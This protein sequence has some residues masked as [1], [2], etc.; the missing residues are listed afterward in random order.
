MI[1]N[2]YKEGYTQNRELSWLR[3]ND[4]VL[5]EANQKEVP[6][7]EREKFISIYSSNLK[8][9]F[10]IRV[11]SL[12]QA[13][14]IKI[15]KIDNKSGMNAAGQ[16]KMIYKV[17]GKS[18]KKRDRIYEELQKKLNKVG[19]ID[20]QI[21][22]CHKEERKYLKEYFRSKIKPLLFP[23]IVDSYHPFPNLRNGMV[24]IAAMVSYSNH[25]AF[26]FTPIPSALPALI[27]LPKSKD[28]L[29]RYVHTEDLI[30]FYL[31][32]I[33][34][35]FTVVEALKIQVL[36]NEDVN[37]DD[38]L[39]DDIIDY[40]KKM[41]K[42]LNLRQHQ[43]PVALFVSKPMSNE[44]KKYLFEHLYLEPKQTYLTSYP[45]DSSFGFELPELFGEAGD[46]LYEP[47][48]P[49][50]SVN[51]NYRQKLFPQ[52]LKHDVLLSYPYENMEPLL[53]LVKEAADDPSVI[54]IKITI[55]RLAKQARLV[56]YL[57]RA[58]E[59][60]KEVITLIE[61]KARFDEQVNIDYS[62]RLEDAGCTVLYGFSEYKVHSKILLITRNSNHK[63]QQVAQIATGNFNEKTAKQYTDLAY[64]T[65]KPGIVK[66]AEAFFRNMMVGKLDGS[67]RNLLVAPVSLKSNLIKLIDREANKKQNGKIVIKINSLTDEELIYHLSLASKAGVEI[68]MIVRGICCLLPGIKGKTENISIRSIVGRY[69]EHSRIYEFGKGKSEVMYISSADFMT[70]NT[71]RRVEIACPILDLSIRQRIN[72]YLDL[73]LKDTIKARTID[74]QGH[75]ERVKE[76]VKID[77]QDLLM[78]TVKGSK[79]QLPIGESR[80]SKVIGVF[81]TVYQGKEKKK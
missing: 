65:G 74:A 55:Y 70:R 35:D 28:S 18:I 26:V 64:F 36:R 50:L 47:Y 45:L 42:V 33:F 5:Q 54:S 9:F 48:V 41:R 39:F 24:V 11:G 58:A 6:L 76:D 20:L 77:S 72:N 7:L 37:V 40:R 79:Q 16:L 17:V 8:E 52:F 4:R 29:I 15:D 19:I 66:D 62:Q 1:K 34:K 14:Q 25:N 73:C 69:L 60:G 68:K 12:S 71:E 78:R 23:Q 38:D 80:K 63:I 2:L 61:L 30:M 49:K 59:N 51:L 57:C 3:F 22:D 53:L 21:N 81:D 27:S 75:Y 43:S 32:D 31:K 10:M 56:E 13:K 67:Y 46:Y 44:M